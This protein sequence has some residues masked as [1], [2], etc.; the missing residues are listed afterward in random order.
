MSDD[1][2][3]QELEAMV[4]HLAKRVEKLE[5]RSRMAPPSSYLRELKREA[6]K[7]LDFWA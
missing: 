7:I 3:I 5:G 2:K 6:S 1:E 4:V